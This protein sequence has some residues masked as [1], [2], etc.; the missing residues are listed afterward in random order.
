[1]DRQFHGPVSVRAALANSYNIPAVRALEQVGVD[2]LKEMAARL[3]ITSLTRDD[4]GLSLTLGS[5]EVSLLEMTGAYQAIANGGQLVPPTA[6]LKI[7]DN[8]G[9]E[10][11]PIRPSARSVLR[12]EHAYLI[13]HILADNEARL[14]GFGPDSPLQLSPPPTRPAPATTSA[15]TGL[16]ATR[17]I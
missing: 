5:G 14:P 13:T 17:P 15:T 4:Y 2:A 10:I 11:E 8:F 16:S 6:I 9:R 1:V 12:A 3:G 7:T